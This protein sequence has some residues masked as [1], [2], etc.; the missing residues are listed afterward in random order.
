MRTKLSIAILFLLLS[1]NFF[2]QDTVR[3]VN[4]KPITPNEADSLLKRQERR[5]GDIGIGFGLDYGGLFGVNASFNPI[6]YMSA[7]ASGGWELIAFGWNVGLVGRLFPA[8]GPKH[9]RPYIKVM[10]GV[11]AAIKVSGWSAYDEVYCG[12]TPGVG[13]EAR[14]GKIRRSGLNVDLNFPIRDGSYFYDLNDVKNNPQIQMKSTPL[15]ISV[16]FGYHFE[17]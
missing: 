1:L 12:V 17:F 10:Y 3:V 13:M 16:S 6:P 5:W 7:F 4:S 11:N 15:P 8:G 14:F 2:G 9:I